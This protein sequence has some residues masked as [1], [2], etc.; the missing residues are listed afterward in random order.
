MSKKTTN[1]S[2]KSAELSPKVKEIQREVNVAL[3]RLYCAED[4]TEMVEVG[5]TIPLNPPMHS[6]QCPK[7]KNKQISHNVYPM[8]AYK[9]KSDAD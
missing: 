4:G 2:E 9:E 6:Y 5:P 7:C 8:L 1:R 3:I